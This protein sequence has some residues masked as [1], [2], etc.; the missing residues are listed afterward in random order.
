MKTKIT[1]SIL[2]LFF[3][4]SFSQQ[5]Y[6]DWEIAKKESQISNKKI[7]IILTGSEWCKPCVKMEK[8]VIE[9]TEF[10]SYANL[11]LIIL[12]INLKRHMD[13]DT[14]LVKDYVYFRDKYQANSLP[15]LILVNSEGKEISKI[16]TG[17][18][19]LEKIMKELIKYK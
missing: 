11:N 17:L 15:S 10:I 18:N 6:D 14:K 7:L 4:F 1:T 2:L 19:S 8:N 16:S 9:N 3:T 5:K 12:E 13:Y